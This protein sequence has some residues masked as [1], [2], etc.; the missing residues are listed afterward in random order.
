MQ[1][2]SV[3]QIECDNQISRLLLLKRYEHPPHGYFDELIEVLRARLY[4]D[5]GKV[6]QHAVE[7]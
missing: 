3:D 7:S 6:E 2:S 5:N 4:A 1:I